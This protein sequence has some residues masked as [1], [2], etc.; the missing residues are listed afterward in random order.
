MA[1]W[2][3]GQE[4]WDNLMFGARLGELVRGIVTTTP[5]P[6]PLIKRLI[7]DGAVRVTRG[8]T[9][10]NQ[11]NISPSTLAYLRA[12]YAGT[13]LGRQELEGQVL[14]DNPRALWRRADIENGRALKAPPLDL[15]IVGV[16]PAAGSGENSDETGIVV[17]G[18]DGQDP[19]HFY[20]LDDATVGQATPD[21]WGR[22]AVTA[23][24]RHEANKIVAEV[25]NGGEM[26]T[27]TI[28]QV[29]RNAPVEAVHASRGKATRAEPVSAL[30]EQ[31]RVHHVGAFPELEDQMAE[32]E[33][34]ASSPD[35]MDALVWA[36]TA[37]MDGAGAFSGNY[38]SGGA[39]VSPSGSDW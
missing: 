3:Y 16:D 12:R 26:V 6:I 39:R 32:W 11:E 9:F 21:Q 27:A 22:A 5:R 31:G 20:V 1:S 15:V 25:N 23:Y 24:Y 38:G 8:S 17:A 7:A 29:D 33:P 34:G 2:K 13:R 28:R 30:Y 35:R 37:L 19:P 14:D 36:V 18:R 10:E 4:T